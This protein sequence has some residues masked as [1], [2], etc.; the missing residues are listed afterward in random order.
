M[1]VC[2]SFKVD[3]MNNALGTFDSATSD[4]PFFNPLVGLLPFFY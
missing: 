2:L 3:R 1:D 4:S